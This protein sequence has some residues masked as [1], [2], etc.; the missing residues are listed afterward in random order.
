MNTSSKLV[1]TLRNSS[2][3]IY[4]Y[5]L[6]QPQ[7]LFLEL[8]RNADYWT[9]PETTGF[10]STCFLGRKD[11]NIPASEDYLLLLPL[12]PPFR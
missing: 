5:R 8:V 4:C 1:V 6:E 10:E 11:S 7:A 3:P 2:V 12:T 9:Q